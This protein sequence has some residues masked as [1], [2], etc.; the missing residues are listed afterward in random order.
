MHRLALFI[1]HT[2][3]LIDYVSLIFRY[4]S[5]GYRITIYLIVCFL[6]SACLSRVPSRV[7]VHADLIAGKFDGSVSERVEG[8]RTAK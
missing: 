6:C 2:S 4:S 8:A 1:L 7:F 5:L 3:R